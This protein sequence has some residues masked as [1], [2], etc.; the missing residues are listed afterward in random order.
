MKTFEFIFALEML[1]PILCS[2]LKVSSYL[3]TY[4]I[5]LL[6]AIELVESLKKSLETMRN[7]ESHFGNVFKKVV[8]NCEDNSIVILIVKREEFQIKLIII[9]ILKIS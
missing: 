7:I 8:N 1:D 4:D 6:T 9:L 5:N 2:I 3:Q